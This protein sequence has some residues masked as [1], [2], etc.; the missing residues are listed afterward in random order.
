MHCCRVELPPWL[1]HACVITYA[2]LR[3][4]LLPQERLETELR[5][6]ARLNE[7]QQAEARKQGQADEKERLQKDI[8][9]RVTSWARGKSIRTMLETL[10]HVVLVRPHAHTT[11]VGAS[12]LMLVCVAAWL[13]LCRRGSFRRVLACLWAAASQT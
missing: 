13:W 10:H 6:Q 11:C 7:L 3:P 4:W 1:A 9:R 2:S 8:G 5:K 12:P